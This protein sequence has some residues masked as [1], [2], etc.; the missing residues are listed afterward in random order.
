MADLEFETQ[1]SRLFMQSP[2]LADQDIFAA[3]V[4]G[5]LENGWAV[6]R[7]AIVT[8]GAG[9]GVVGA[10]QL[11]SARFLSDMRAVSDDGVKALHE[12]ITRVVG[13]GMDLISISPGG[14]AMWLA[15]GLGVLA[16]A[17][18]VTRLIDEF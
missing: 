18:A 14:E 13:R 17:F 11:V 16:L 10:A 3:K 15:A 4:A 6:R 1:V 9:V 2:A 5:R 12:G 7:A 8:I